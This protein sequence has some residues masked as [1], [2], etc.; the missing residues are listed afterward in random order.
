MNFAAAIRVVLLVGLLG[1]PGAVLGD[2]AAEECGGLRGLACAANEFCEFADDSCG[3]A[4]RTGT[5][6]P[7]PGACTREYQPVCG[8][9]GKTYGNDC[10][11][12]SAGVAKRGDGAC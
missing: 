9:D 2:E 8:C 11:R 4:D 7:R 1:M 3:A 10:D 12:R 5:C 6:M